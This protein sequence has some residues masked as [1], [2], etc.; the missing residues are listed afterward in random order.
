MEV[1]TIENDQRRLLSPELA[2][3]LSRASAAVSWRA[4]EFVAALILSDLYPNSLTLVAAFGLTDTFVQ[5]ATGSFLGAYVDRT[6]RYRSAVVMYIVQHV[7]ICASALAAAGAFFLEP[8]SIGRA[9]LSAIVV[10]AGTLAGAGATGSAL[11]VEQVWVVAICGKDKEALTSLN[12]KMRAVDLAALLLAPL[13]AAAALQFTTS[14]MF[15]IAFAVY[16]GIS[17]FPEAF[18]LRL[19]GVALNAGINREEFDSISSKEKGITEETKKDEDESLSSSSEMVLDAERKDSCRVNYYPLVLYSKQPSALLMFALALLYF[20]VLSFHGVM[21]VYLKVEGSSD[22]S[23]SIFRGAGAVFGIFSTVVFPCVT[24]RISLPT[25]SAMSVLFQLIFISL[26]AVPLS[27]NILFSRDVLLNLFQG[28]TAVSRFGLWL[29][30]LAI[31]QYT[32]E[33]T[34]T[35]V[36]G[37]VQGTQR[38]VCALFEL[39]S[40]VATLVFSD[41][42]QFSI[43]MYFSLAAVALSSLICTYVALSKQRDFE[44]AKSI[45]EEPLLLQK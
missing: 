1:N 23:I 38:S 35:K 41:P 31:S 45:I 6:E 22:V 15:A 3:L 36:L 25:L 11:S 34:D 5:I 44:G 4:W 13:A 30:D 43:L 8:S 24:G 20:T 12:S 42:T 14:W 18:L 29:A 19:A 40:Y 26:G 27:L 16:S 39:L 28:F 10:L 33:T 9:G 21:T 37:S 7:L 17:F 32:Q 2:L